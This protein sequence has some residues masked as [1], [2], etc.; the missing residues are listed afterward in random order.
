[1]PRRLG[2]RALLFLVLS[3]ASALPVALLGLDQAS[4]FAKKQ[5]ELTDRQAEAAAHASADELSLSMSDAVHAAESFADQVVARGSFAPEV[6]RSSMTAHTS[7]HPDQLGAYVADATG[8]SLM[9][10]TLSG[11]ILAGGINYSDRDYFKEILRTKH[12]AISRAQVGR[13]THVLSISVAAPIHDDAGRFLGITCI[14]IDL[15]G[16][17]ARAKRA[18]G[19]LN[20]GRLAIVDGEG[21]ILADSDSARLE[22]HDVSKLALFR[23]A[24]VGVAQLRVGLDDRGREVRSVAVGLGAPIA[25]WRVVAM[26]P[27]SV[28]DVQTRRVRYQVVAVA[29]ALILMTLILAAWLAVWLARPLQG[30]AATAL[31]VSRGEFP[32]PPTLPRSAPREMVQVVDAIGE[33]ITQ[34]RAYTSELESKVAARTH[35]LSLA[36][37]ELSAALTIIRGNEQSMRQDIEQGRLFQEKMLP[38]ALSRRDLDIATHYLPLE[39]VSGDIFDVCELA[40]DHVRLFLAD[41]TGHGVQASMRTIW[42]KTT[43]DRLKAGAATP[44]DLLSALN[45]ALLSEFPGGDLICAASCI[46]VRQRG[47]GAG[48]EVQYSNAANEPLYVLSLDREAREVH[49]PGPLLGAREIAWPPAL[50]FDL[51]QGELLLIASDG[52]GEQMNLGHQRFEDELPR[53]HACA[54]AAATLSAV[55]AEF[56][57]FRGETPIADDITLIAVTR[58][59]NLTSA[60]VG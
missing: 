56:A 2:V 21:R 40:P 48:L 29:I 43:Y 33:M 13:S 45:S 54:D 5:I 26:S 18:I 38:P 57:A 49:A 12:A 55:L 8:R 36:N 60:A 19:G 23:G 50:R 53:F 32:A 27:Q 3:T 16:V 31:A 37:D 25:G 9:N 41:V 42:L 7:H 34:L 10:M 44:A 14:S 46:D 11:E 30:V 15:R 24:Q 47:A 52:I 22:A 17:A 28:V 35:D 1:M 20:E 4:A 51:Q 6:L 39:R 58:A 59:A